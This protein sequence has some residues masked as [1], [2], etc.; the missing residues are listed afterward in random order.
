M[1][2]SPRRNFVTPEPGEDWTALA[3]RVLPQEPPGS[4]IARL[5]SWNLHLLLRLLGRP[6]RRHRDRV[7]VP[8]SAST[9]RGT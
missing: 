1:G 3:L 6:P 5:K 8:G 4:A 2:L 7:A 9:E